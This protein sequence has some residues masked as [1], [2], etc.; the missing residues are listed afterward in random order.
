[1]EAQETFFL[2]VQEEYYEIEKDKKALRMNLPIQKGFFILQLAKLRMNQ[3]YYEFMMRFVSPEN[4]QYCEM[5]TDS[6]YMAQAGPS[7]ESVIKPEMLDVYH[8]GLNDFHKGDPHVEA[9]DSDHWFPCTC[10][11][12]H[13]NFD[14]RTVRYLS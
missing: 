6:A 11:S 3:F 8:S 7:L 13:S 12:E 14:K 9:D 2:L 5:D 4:F 10:C 1:M